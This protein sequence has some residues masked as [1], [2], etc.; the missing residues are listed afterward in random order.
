VRA[1]RHTPSRAHTHTHTHT[2]LDIYIYM[3]INLNKE[4]SLCLMR[5]HIILMSILASCYSRFILDYGSCPA[6]CITEPNDVCGIKHLSWRLRRVSESEAL[7]LCIELITLPPNAIC[8]K[9]YD[10]ER[11]TNSSSHF[12]P[13]STTCVMTIISSICDITSASSVTFCCT[14]LTC[15]C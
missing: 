10:V 14:V 6:S 1:R 2:H 9:C 5:L 15:H 11:P 13:L 7:Q 3:F 12:H 8:F 4:L